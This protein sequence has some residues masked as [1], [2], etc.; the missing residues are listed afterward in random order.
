VFR[1]NFYG[2][3]N[4]AGWNKVD[5][6]SENNLKKWEALRRKRRSERSPS[7]QELDV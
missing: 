6:G 4:F 5:G 7:N 3:C 2:E 1:I